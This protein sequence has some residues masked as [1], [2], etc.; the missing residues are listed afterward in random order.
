[1]IKYI[2]KRLFQSIL[3]V[4]L[5][6]CVVFTLLRLM[7]SD[8][9]F[10][11]D[12]LMKFTEAQKFAKLERLGLMDICP[13]CEGTGLVNGEA[14][15]TCR[16]NE[17]QPKGTGYVNRSILAQLGDFFRDMLQVRVFN[18]KGKEVKSIEPISLPNYLSE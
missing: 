15:H 10:T 1:M 18:A 4:L 13:D 16:E 7:P 2:I 11:E 6:V 17:L 8:Y 14:C 5:V 12:E 3:V 9:F